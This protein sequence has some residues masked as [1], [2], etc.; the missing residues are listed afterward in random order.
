MTKVVLDAVKLIDL[1]TAC[2]PPGAQFEG[3]PI[4]VYAWPSTKTVPHH[5]RVLPVRKDAVEQVSQL[6]L[7]NFKTI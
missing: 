1:W 3:I 7:Q 5:G 6:W 2:I 4:H